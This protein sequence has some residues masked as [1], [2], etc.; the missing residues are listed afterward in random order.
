MGFVDPRTDFGFKRIFGSSQSKPIL[1]NF[2]NAVVYDNESR[3]TDLEILDPHQNP[4]LYTLKQSIL[5]I[6]VI[7]DNGT[8]VLIEMQVL[9]VKAFAERIIYN[10]AKAYVNQLEQGKGYLDLKPVISLTIVDFL[11]FP[12]ADTPSPNPISRY[13]L[14]NPETGHRCSPHLELIFAEL[15]KLTTVPEE[16]KK[17]GELWLYFI[18]QAGKLEQVPDVLT[19]TDFETAFEIANESQL[20]PEEYELAQK[21]RMKIW[22]EWGRQEYAREEGLEKGR[23]EGL[24]QGREEGL[25]QGREEGLEQGREEVAEK[26]L[27]MGLS[28]DT[29]CRATGLT[30]TVVQGLAEAIASE[31]PDVN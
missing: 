9:P 20:S 14:L 31:T 16:L 12:K 15:P 25:E 1:R 29:V 18:Q 8:T 10:T 6:K 23:E 21:Q 26:M 28:T 24:E 5:D 2:L 22:D 19:S 11:L 4:D 7:L 27:A 30:E 3:I 13:Q 17:Q